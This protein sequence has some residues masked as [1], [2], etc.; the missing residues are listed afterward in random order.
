LRD[1]ER[2]KRWAE[3]G[4]NGAHK[5]FSWDA[6]A[7]NYMDAI[8]ELLGTKHKARPIVPPKSRL[9][10]VDRI[11]VCDVDDT[12]LGDDEAMHA[13]ADRLRQAGANVGF[14]VATGRRIESVLKAISDHRLPTPDLLITSVG[15]EIYYGHQLVKDR[16][17]ERHTDYRWEPEALLE[18]MQAFDGLKL[19]PATEQRSHK[20]S[21]YVD[22]VKA[23]K[24]REVIRYLRQ[25][26]LHANVVYSH[27]AF[28]DLLP[29]RASKGLAL[30]YLA[31][32]WGLPPERMLVAG[33]SGNDADMLLGNRLGVVVGNFTR[34]LAR[35][36]G[37][38]RIFFAKGTH[39]WGVLEGLEHYDFLGQ[40]RIPQEEWEAS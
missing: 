33:Q 34:E 3:N 2:W 9:P 23:P 20:I 12:L 18:A 11:V 28:L 15:T 5:H 21:Y 19:Q 40:I 7:A 17:W 10:T 22:A 14:G 39:A 4:L 32:K 31:A 13:L 27:S 26:D 1:R 38:P 29:I 25:H 37:R 36:R 24:P 30:G 35:L 16:G 6:H 8:H